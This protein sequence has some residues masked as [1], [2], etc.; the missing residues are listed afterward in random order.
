M[1]PSLSHCS[2]ASTNILFFLFCLLCDICF[3]FS[4]NGIPVIIE[5]L[6]C[7]C[8]AFQ[9]VIYCRSGV[10]SL[11][12]ANGYCENS[13]GSIPPLVTT[14]GGWPSG[15]GSEPDGGDQGVNPVSPS[16]KV[17]SRNIVDQTCPHGAAPTVMESLPLQ[18]RCECRGGRVRN[19]TR[20]GAT[21]VL[22]DDGRASCSPF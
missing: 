17:G 14:F 7:Q 13:W 21:K 2:L 22:S 1:H 6:V 12:N 5:N 19:M 18:I 10:R 11:K 15:R 9:W 4:C 3:G 16:S 20:S 8:D